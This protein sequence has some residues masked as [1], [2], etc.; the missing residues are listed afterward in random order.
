MASSSHVL[1]VCVCVCDLASTAL[2]ACVRQARALD[3][4]QAID[5]ALEAVGPRYREHYSEW[6]AVH[7]QATD[8]QKE[9]GCA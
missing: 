4:R 8:T 6:G 9:G 2:C 3:I 1:C 7:R 5:T